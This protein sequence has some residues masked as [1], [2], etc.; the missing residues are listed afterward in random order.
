MLFEQAAMTLVLE[1][2][3]L[4]AARIIGVSNAR[5]W[6]VIQFYVSQALSKIDLSGARPWL[7]MKPPPSGAT[8]TSP[9]SS[10]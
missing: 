1:M 3:V 5:L 10:T 6:Q 7:W 8:T 4:A 9:C 2:P